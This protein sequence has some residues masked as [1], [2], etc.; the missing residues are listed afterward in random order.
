MA[1]PKLHEV[2]YK[3]DMTPLLDV[4]FQL[5]TFFIMVS[6]FSQEVYDQ[7]IRLPVAGSASP[8]SD[9]IEDKIVL[10]VDPEGRLLFNNRL[11]TGQEAIDQ[12]ELQADLARLNAEAVGQ[13]ISVG[14]PLPTTVIL[15]ADRLAR[16]DDV[17][18]LIRACQ[19]NGFTNFDLR[20]ESRTLR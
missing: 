13:E 1:R 15:R 6:N 14:D 5:M 7:R 20:A 16:F 12:I 8:I 9:P 11:F 2:R 18:R 3:P 10:N 4:V 17:F 19:D